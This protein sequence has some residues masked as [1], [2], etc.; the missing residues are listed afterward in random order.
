M[1]AFVI[2]FDYRSDDGPRLVGPFKSRTDADRWFNAQNIKTAEF[3]VVKL[4][5][6]EKVAYVE[7]GPAGEDGEQ[8]C[9]SCGAL[10]GHRH[11]A[12]CQRKVFYADGVLSTK[13]DDD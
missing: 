5:Q 11:A 10:V 8:R 9:G 7:S 13:N 2:E 4:W 6:P 3:S 12:D 1:S